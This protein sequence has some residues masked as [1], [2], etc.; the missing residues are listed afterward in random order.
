MTT[1]ICFAAGGSLGGGPEG[2]VVDY[3][4]PPR[5]YVNY[6]DVTR[7]TKDDHALVSRVFFGCGASGVRN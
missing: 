7:T 2:V 6:F 5:E 3:V 1:R 4:C